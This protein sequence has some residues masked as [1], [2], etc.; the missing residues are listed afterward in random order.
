MS[1]RGFLFIYTRAIL[2]SIWAES[3]RTKEKEMKVF[4]VSDMQ[5]GEVPQLGTLPQ[6]KELI[7]KMLTDSSEVIAAMGLGSAFN[8]KP[9]LTSDIDLLVI[10]HDHIITCKAT[11]ELVD[12][13]KR[14]YHWP[15]NIIELSESQAGKGH[16]TIPAGFYR[17]LNR[18][19]GQG[20]NIKCTEGP[21]S[22]RALD[23]VKEPQESLAI[24]ACT[25]ITRKGR[26]FRDIQTELS[27]YEH[28]DYCRALS[29]IFT[30][31]PHIVREVL[32]T[33]THLAGQEDDNVTDHILDRYRDIFQD[34][35]EAQELLGRLT[36]RCQ[37][38][39]N[40]FAHCLLTDDYEYY[41]IWV[42]SAALR[43]LP[44]AVHFAHLNYYLASGHSYWTR[45]ENRVHG[46]AHP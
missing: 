5:C 37:E 32:L 35:K 10:V 46:V 31:F 2:V 27:E 36:E 1:V 18:T 25:Y 44:V 7:C 15:L 9:K 6:V 39:D 20:H 12:Q 34:E 26:K 29:E 28:R 45:R 19:A 30:A 17:Y 33:R 8:G 16:H 24:S 11:Q 13:V 38:Y 21:D 14:D 42:E 4:P 3:P 23:L 22:K 40:R 43:M 41:R